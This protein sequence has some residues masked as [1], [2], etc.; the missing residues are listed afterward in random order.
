MPH[1]LMPNVFGTC[2]SK[3]IILLDVVRDRYAVLS[4]TQSAALAPHLGLDDKLF[5]QTDSIQSTAIL[6]KL[7]R[8]NWIS[9]N[10]FPVIDAKLNAL[11]PSPKTGGMS[12]NGWK[13]P[14]EAF[15]HRPAWASIAKATLILRSVHKCAAQHG[16]AGLLRLCDQA[17][18]EAAE[19][20]RFGQPEEYAPFV[21]TLNWACL[22][23]PRSTKCLEWSVAL[24]LLCARASLALKLVIGVQSFPFYAHAW[25]EAADVVIGDSALRRKE[26]SVIL[27]FPHPLLDLSHGSSRH[28]LS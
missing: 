14:D 22:F 12:A 26:L 21:N 13:L 7:K 1:H 24:T 27:E 17:H 10:L 3:Q 23:Y 16:L 28:R 4:D 6:E 25:S 18:H 2:F 19:H 9:T 15:A 5:A 20:L 8:A 11:S